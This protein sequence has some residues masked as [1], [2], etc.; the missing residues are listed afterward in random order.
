[1]KKANSGLAVSNIDVLEVI[2]DQIS[3]DI[4]TAISNDVTN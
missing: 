3:M 4:I 1:M 2:S